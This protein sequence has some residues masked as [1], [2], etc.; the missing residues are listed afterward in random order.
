MVSVAVQTDD[1]VEDQ[2]EEGLTME[3]VEASQKC[4][5]VEVSLGLITMKSGDD[6]MDA[7]MGVLGDLK[8]VDYEILTKGKE[9]RRSWAG[10]VIEGSDEKETRRGVVLR[11]ELFVRVRGGIVIWDCRL[12]GASRLLLRIEFYLAVR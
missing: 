6:L 5:E 12:E 1:V 2:R 10:L 7:S 3:G 8:K 11:V 9:V 4:D